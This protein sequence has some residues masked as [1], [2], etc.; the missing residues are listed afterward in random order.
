MEECL[1][2]KTHREEHG[3]KTGQRQGKDGQ[4][5]LYN[6]W[7]RLVEIAGNE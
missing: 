5:G 2:L 3:A 6:A 7:K 4:T 1:F